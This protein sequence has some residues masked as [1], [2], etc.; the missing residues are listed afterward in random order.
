MAI[1]YIPSSTTDLGSNGGNTTNYTVSLTL[2]GGVGHRLRVCTTTDLGV[3][4]L[5][6]I[7]LAGTPL[8]LENKLATGGSTRTVYLHIL[9]NPA[10]GTNSLV[11]SKTANGFFLPIAVEY[12]GVI[13]ANAIDATTT[14]DFAPGGTAA[15]TLTTALATVADNCWAA[16]GLNQNDDSGT[17]T[18]GA[19]LTKRIAN[20]TFNMPSYFDSNGAVH[21]AGSYSMTTNVTPGVSEI[22]HVVASF[23]PTAAVNLGFLPVGQIDPMPGR[24]EVVAY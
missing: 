12:S 5:T 21:P 16:L 17:I 24:P 8:T 1:A 4:D 6:G 7:T 9:D 14:Q 13:G 19:G 15:S 11:F 10:G 3:D 2:V 23:A 20:A 22:I 18:A